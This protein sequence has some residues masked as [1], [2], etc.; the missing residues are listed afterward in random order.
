[1]VDL[2]S[3]CPGHGPVP[4]TDARNEREQSAVGCQ[5]ARIQKVLASADQQMVLTNLGGLERLNLPFLRDLQVLGKRIVVVLID[6]GAIDR[7][8]PQPL[9]TDD[10]SLSWEAFDLPTAPSAVIEHGA[11]KVDQRAKKV[12]WRLELVP[13]TKAEFDI[14]SLFANR[15]G[16]AICYRDI[17]DVVHSAGFHAGD[18]ETGYYTNV[19][20]LIKRIRQKFMQIDPNFA[21]IENYRGFGYRWRTAAP[22]AVRARFRKSYGR[23]ST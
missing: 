21:H 11:L 9:L 3:Q 2:L 4:I 17:Y 19:R 22:P 14:I 15:I 23:P 10:P 6:S 8:P 12:T 5:Q 20:S 16:D 1:M 13:L 7:S 18:G